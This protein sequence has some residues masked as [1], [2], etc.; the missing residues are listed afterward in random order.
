MKR[1]NPN[2]EILPRYLNG[3]LHPNYWIFDQAYGI[4]TT[5]E[6][7]VSWWY[8]LTKSNE[9]EQSHESFVQGI[10][11]STPR[12]GKIQKVHANLLAS[13]GQF[14]NFSQKYLGRKWNVRGSATSWLRNNVG[15]DVAGDYSRTFDPA[16]MLD[17]RHY[18]LSMR[19]TFL[20][21]KDFFI[22]LFT[23]GRWETTYYNEKQIVNHYLA[24]FLLG[25]EFRPGS[26]FFLAY[27]EGREDLGEFNS[28]PQFDL[29]NRTLVA[30]IQYVFHR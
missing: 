3:D 4:R 27:N 8:A 1:H 16:G 6:M 21:T 18:R 29:I 22:R 12:S 24:S 15:L 19:N 14:Y 26:W 13:W 9:L 23:Q 30:K 20:L 25:W 17:G 7:Y 11:L 5:K 28:H 2:I 10:T